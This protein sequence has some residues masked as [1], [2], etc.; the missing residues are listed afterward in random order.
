M[1]RRRIAIALSVLA[2]VSAFA[3]SASSQT[4]PSQQIRIIVPVA[5]GGLTI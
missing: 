3:G 1:K 5:A 4:Y 2:M